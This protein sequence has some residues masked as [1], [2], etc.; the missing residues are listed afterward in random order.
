MTHCNFNQDRTKTTPRFLCVGVDRQVAAIVLVLL[1]DRA[2]GRVIPIVELAQLA[3][4]ESLP[5]LDLLLSLVGIVFGSGN[6]LDPVL[7]L[8]QLDA[9]FHQEGFALGVIAK[10]FSPGTFDHRTASSFA[11]QAPQ[12]SSISP[13]HSWT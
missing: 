9:T 4:C 7:I 12:L 8:L 5:N 13:P 3:G 6:S 11:K 10:L 1:L 2:L